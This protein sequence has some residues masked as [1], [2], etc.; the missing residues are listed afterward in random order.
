M[1]EIDSIEKLLQEATAQVY[2]NGQPAG[3]GFFVGP[4]KLLTCAH[5]IWPDLT[6][7][8]DVQIYWQGQ[9]YKASI[10]EWPGQ[11]PA[12]EEDVALLEVEAAL[13]DHQCVLLCGE[14]RPGSGLYSYAYPAKL[15]SDGT[16]V[17]F[18]AAGPAGRKNELITFQHGAV[19]PGMSGAPLLDRESGSVCGMIQFSLDLKSERGGQGLQARVILDR[20]P[21]VA[22]WQRAFHGQN[23][24]WLEA[25]S[26]EQRRLLRQH[27]PQSRDLLQIP[28]GGRKLKVFISHSSA[29]RDLKLKADLEKQLEHLRQQGL[30]E[31][32]ASGELS[33]G[34]ESSELQRQLEEADIIL[35]LISADYLASEQCYNREMQQAMQR[36]EAG[37]A[38]VIPI[39]LRPTAGL[40][41]SPFGKLQA[42]PRYQ[43]AVSKFRDKDTVLK[44]IAEELTRVIKELQE[45]QAHT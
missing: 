26:G 3:T 1:G 27:C 18:Q 29:G 33:G 11:D 39:K 12:P 45:E 9:Y 38:R 22:G 21:A 4:G 30:I 20:L 42:L 31:S 41:T 43:P 17:I 10:L 40:D 28:R 24:R 23:R 5:V 44:E 25:L 7:K 2:L 32:Y 6:G 15:A 14:A 36:H 8:A 16:S 13:R 19:E 37:T 34:K 35:L